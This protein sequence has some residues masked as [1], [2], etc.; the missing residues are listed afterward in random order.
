MFQKLMDVVLQG[1]SGVICYIDDILV[2]GKDEQSRFRL[3]QEKCEFLMPS[4][5]YLGHQI[6][7]DGIRAL[8]NKVA[9]I[10]NAPAPTNLQELRSFLRL[11]NYYC[12]FIPNLATILHPLNALLQADRKWE[13]SQEC[14]EAFQLAK[15]KL[16][17]QKSLLT[18]IQHYQS[19]SQLML[20]PMG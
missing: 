5:E 20:Q 13:W 16:T 10:A 19:T 6:N 14:K 7:Q 18:T 12:K 1:I 4:V 2:S 3:K 8:P 17:S 9:A 15:D 11:L